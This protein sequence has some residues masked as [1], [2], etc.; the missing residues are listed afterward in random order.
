MRRISDSTRARRARRKSRQDQRKR[1]ERSQHR[2]R[3]GCA[4]D[5]KSLLVMA[6]TAAQQ[7]QADDTIADDHD[8]RKNRGASQPRIV[9]WRRNHRGDNQR[10][11]NHRDCDGQ[12]E[13]AERL[14]GTVCNDLGVLDGR[15][16]RCDQDRPCRR[17][18]DAATADEVR[19]EQNDPG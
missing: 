6:R 7:A 1:R 15:K 18:D 4:V 10:D 16:H 13:R 8:R 5:L 11:F 12:D 2:Q 19:H 3:G 14:T 17:S 9:R